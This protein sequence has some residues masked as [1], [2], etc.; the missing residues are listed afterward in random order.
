[1]MIET[2]RYRLTLKGDWVQDPLSSEQQMV[3]RSSRHATTLSVSSQEL[4][5]ATSGDTVTAAQYLLTMRLDAEN[6]VAEAN[7]NPIQIS[8]P[9]LIAQPWGASLA[10]YGF[11][12]NGRQFHYSAAVWPKQILSLFVESN[13]LTQH[14]LKEVMAE[15]LGGIEFNGDAV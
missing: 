1:M 7:N 15:V 10:Y 2:P 4:Q 13:R 11:D 5:G 12:A 3:F 8:E 6:K 14:Q 9:K